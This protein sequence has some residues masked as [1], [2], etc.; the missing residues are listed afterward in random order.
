M[1]TP[2]TLLALAMAT[3]LAFSACTLPTGDLIVYEQTAPELAHASVS[4]EGVWESAPWSAPDAPWLPYPSQ[5]T[6][7]VEHTLG[8][9]PR[10]VNVYL[11]FDAMGSEPAAAAGDLARIVSVD[12]TTLSVRNGTNAQLFARIVAY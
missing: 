1:T 9:E 10:V 6:V 8:R 4:P 7:Q 2:R 12:E 5:A 3:G 11:S